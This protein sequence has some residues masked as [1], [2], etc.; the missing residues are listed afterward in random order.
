MDYS[1]FTHSYNSFHRSI[2]FHNSISHPSYHT[3]SAEQYPQEPV[4]H[5]LPNQTPIF[6]HGYTPTPS[7]SI[8]TQNTTNT[9]QQLQQP[10]FY[11]QPPNTSTLMSHHVSL[12]SHQ[13]QTPPPTFVSSHTAPPSLQQQ[14][15]PSYSQTPS[16]TSFPR[17]YQQQPQTLNPSLPPSRLEMKLSIFD[18]SEDAYW[19]IICSEKSFN[20]R[21]RRVSDAERLMECSFA[22]K[23]SALTWW[24]SWYLANPNRSWDSFT[25]ALLWHFKPEWKPILPIE[26]EE[27]EPTENEKVPEQL[28]EKKSTVIEATKKL[29]NGGNLQII[30]EEDKEKKEQESETRHD[31]SPTSSCPTLLLPATESKNGLPTTVNIT[32]FQFTTPYELLSPSTRNKFSTHPPLEK[33]PPM[34]PEINVFT[35]ADLP[36][37]N[38]PVP[39]PSAPTPPQLSFSTMPPPPSLP[40]PS[41]K[42][43]DLNSTSESILP[44]TPTSRPPRKPPDQSL[45]TTPPLQFDSIHFLSDSILWKS[46]NKSWPSNE[47]TIRVMHQYPIRCRHVAICVL[48]LNYGWYVGQRNF[49]SGETHFGVSLKERIVFIAK[50]GQPVS[51]SRDIPTCAKFILSFLMR[52]M[53][54]I[55]FVMDEYYGPKSC[56]IQASLHHNPHTLVG[57]TPLHTRPACKPPDLSLNLEDKVQVNPAAMIED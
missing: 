34:P 41:P 44:L 27:E 17:Y 46:G 24:L 1:T 28:E 22:M 25:C 40:R 19:W 3:Y 33:P 2:H 31:S 8:I 55:I 48:I 13:I 32:S 14:T 21:N 54:H 35:I 15:H 47:R 26:G 6:N 20:S 36:P 51:Q 10:F 43:P 45:P 5:Q 12:P 39:T 42:P 23:G 30:Q 56:V 50:V 57:L 4:V 16:S 37:P 18:G 11:Q 7:P 9:L 29:V 49:G 53:G 52:K 38:P